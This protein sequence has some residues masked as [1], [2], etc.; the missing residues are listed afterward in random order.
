MDAPYGRWLNVWRRM[1]KNALSH[2]EQILEATSHKIAAVKSPTTFLETI[3]ISRTRHAGRPSVGRPARTYLQQ[4]CTDTG[5][6]LEDLPEAMGNWDEWWEK[7]RE[8]RA[9]GSTWWW[10]WLIQIIWS[11]LFKEHFMKPGKTSY[12]RK[13]IWVLCF[14]SFIFIIKSGWH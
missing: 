2:I 7:V 10:W 1:H 14:I 8:I 4:L 9:S 3:Q 5:C 11:R 6:S 12:Q 13:M